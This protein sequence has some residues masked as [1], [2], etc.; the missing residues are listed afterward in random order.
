MGQE[1]ERDPSHRK[2]PL[3]TT[4]NVLIPLSQAVDLAE[5]RLPGHAQRVAFISMSVAEKLGLDRDSQL[6]VCY[7]GLMHDI[8]VIAASADIATST[9]GDERMVFASLPLLTPDEALAGAGDTSFAF[10][11]RVAGHV[12]HGVRA[13]RLLGLPNE[14]VRAIATHHETWD[15]QG[16]PDGLVG[17]ETPVLGRIVCLA[18]HTEA[19]I[20]QTS[21]LLARRSFSFWMS[22]AR[23]T[24]TDPEIVNAL[25]E[26]G[27]GDS[28]W[29]GLCSDDLNAELTARCQ[30][31]REGR[32][33][34]L[35]PMSEAFSQLVDARLS[36]TED[37]SARVARYAELLGKAA[38]LNDQAVQY[39]RVAALLHDVGQLSMS[40][41]VLSKPGIFTIEEMGALHLHPIYSA[42]IVRGIPGM[43]TVASWVVSHHERIDGRGYPEGREGDDIPLESRILAIADGYVAITSDR[44]HR[45]RAEG[46]EAELRLRNGAGSQWDADLVDLFLTKV[47]PDRNAV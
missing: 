25:A 27:G 39:L 9:S 15:G 23:G 30:R 11:D 18:D 44:P 1:L 41:R 34:R 4:S 21:P 38:G 20:A 17:P 28:F 35:M 26:L 46:R 40:E 24:Q 5:G 19:L 3:H 36:F 2:L 22:N 29:L 47:I 42:D 7:A 31:I 33:P 43:E 10:V 37:I 8:G 45:P 13:A 16:Y 32:G 6:E 14:T 12:D